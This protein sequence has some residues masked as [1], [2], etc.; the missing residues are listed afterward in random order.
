MR[1]AAIRLAV[2]DHLPVD[3]EVPRIGQRSVADE[4]AATM[5]VVRIA[6][7]AVCGDPIDPRDWPPE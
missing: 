7:R 6:A 5:M 2:P 3:R 1:I 4:E